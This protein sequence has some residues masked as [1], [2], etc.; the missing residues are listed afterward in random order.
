MSDMTLGEALKQ[1]RELIG[2]DESIG[3]RDALRTVIV[4]ATDMERLK[5][6]INRLKLWLEA[7]QTERDE[8]RERVGDLVLAAR[9]GH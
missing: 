4:E 9:E 2:K 8:L 1:L 3:Y 7:A 5:S 6:E